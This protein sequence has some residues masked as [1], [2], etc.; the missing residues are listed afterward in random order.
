MHDLFVASQGKL[1]GAFQEVSILDHCAIAGRETQTSHER[2]KERKGGAVA[3]PA[4]I[5]ALITRSLR[6]RAAIETNN[7][8]LNHTLESPT[9]YPRNGP[10][11][12][13]D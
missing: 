12:G 5:L 1:R 13:N 3:G 10:Q 7:L 2:R 9:R 6:E 4:F 11:L 8:G